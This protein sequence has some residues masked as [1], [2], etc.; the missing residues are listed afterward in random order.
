MSSFLGSRYYALRLGLAR[1]KSV[2]AC[3][4]DYFLD[5]EPTRLSSLVRI[6]VD[7]AASHVSFGATFMLLGLRS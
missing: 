3:V 4:G 6:G 7:I 2:F 5:A 1:A